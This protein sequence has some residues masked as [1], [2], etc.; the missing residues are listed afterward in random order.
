MN[1]SERL[2]TVPQNVYVIAFL[3][4]FA[5]SAFF[6]YFTGEDTRLLERKIQSKQRDY[7]EVLQ[8][9]DIYEAKKRAADKVGAGHVEKRPVTLASVEELVGKSFIG[10]ALSTLHPVAERGEKGVQQMAV[11][12]KVTNAPLGEVISFVK[13]AEGSGFY[14]GKLRLSLSTANTGALDVQATVMEKRSNG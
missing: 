9:K 8:L 1:V 13:N 12:I 14:V 11:E 2:R 7:A 10:G 5:I 3:G 4:I 6:V